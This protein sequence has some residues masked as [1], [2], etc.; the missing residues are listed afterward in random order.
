MG[1]GYG[2]GLAPEREREKGSVFIF[3]LRD[4]VVFFTARDVHAVVE[5]VDSL[6]QAS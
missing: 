3:F 5:G 6:P 1:Y 2:Y 4:K